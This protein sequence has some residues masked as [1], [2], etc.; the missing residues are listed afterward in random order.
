MIIE[1]Y[2]TKQI[3]EMEVY[4]LG[5]VFEQYSDLIKNSKILDFSPKVEVW[6]SSASNKSLSYFSHG[7]FRYF[8]KFPSVVARHLIKKYTKE[9]DL[10]LDPMCGSGTTALESLLLKREALCNDINPL[11]VLISKVK[12]TKINKDKAI[13]YFGN[14]KKLVLESKDLEIE[15]L[16][17]LKNPNHWFREDTRESLTKI[18]KAI[19]VVKM[20]KDYKEFFM[21]AFLS[22]VRRV[23]N[24]T[25]QQ[26]RLFLDIETAVSDALPF[27]EKKVIDM[28]DSLSDIP[29][30]QDI[31]IVQSS[32]ID[33]NTEKKAKLIICHPPYFNSYKYS[34]INSLE[35]SW[36]GIDHADIRKNEIR[37]F[38]KVGKSEKVEQYVLDM[39]NVLRNLVKNLN[40]DGKLALMI[41]DTVI[42]GEYIPVTNLLLTK[43][44]DV[45]D[46]ELSAL[47]IPKYTEASWVAS[48]RRKS[49]N[50]GVN[51]CDL[52]VILK[53]K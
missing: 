31:E 6:T 19:D 49:N 40:D 30:K 50:V 45:Y 1:E 42:K 47:R 33:L 7:I 34:G 17:G 9:G 37:E 28:V 16:I 14:I 52:I 2:K 13:E 18:K 32:A 36:Y 51:L 3:P 26:G 12:V 35:L 20:E 8:G 23:S 24:A 43:L 29:L 11:S 25:T 27:F 48:Q 53:K 21:V 5:S 10:V 44:K 4:E 46:V 22:I 38:F 39:E 15:E 41:G